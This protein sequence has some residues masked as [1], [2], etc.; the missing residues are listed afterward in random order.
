MKKALKIVACLLIAL[1]VTLA[2]NVSNASAQECD[3][4]TDPVCHSTLYPGECESV[5]LPGYEVSEIEISFPPD[6]PFPRFYPPPKIYYN[7]E[8][9]DELVS[10]QL[11]VTGTATY[12]FNQPYPCDHG[13]VCNAKDPIAPGYPMLFD[14]TWKN[15]SPN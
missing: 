15:V 3:W 12:D 1:T 2:T 13:E 8:V 6:A 4:S 7:I 9:C 5:P 11:E 14:L 10:A